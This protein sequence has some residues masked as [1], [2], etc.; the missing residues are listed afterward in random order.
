MAYNNPYFYV[1][2]PETWDRPH[3]YLLELDESPRDYSEEEQKNIYSASELN[4]DIGSVS[5]YRRT[6]LLLEAPWSEPIPLEEEEAYVQAIIAYWRE[7]IVDKLGG[8]YR[9]LPILTIAPT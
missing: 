8:F 9:R 7:A 4:I 6:I 1:T 3:F 5:G 2:F